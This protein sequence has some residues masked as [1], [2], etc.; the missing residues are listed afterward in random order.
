MSSESMRCH[1]VLPKRVP[2]PPQIAP[3]TSAI[4]R[5]AVSPRETFGFQIPELSRLTK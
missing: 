3:P 1:I 4:V 5:A 2:D